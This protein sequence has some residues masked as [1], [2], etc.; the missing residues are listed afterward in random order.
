MISFSS[1]LKIPTLVA[2]PLLRY[3]SAPLERYAHDIFFYPIL[4]TEQMILH[5]S[6]VLCSK[7]VMSHFCSSVKL[8]RCESRWIMMTRALKSLHTFVGL[9]F[10]CLKKNKNKNNCDILLVS[11]KKC[12]PIENSFDA[13]QSCLTST[14]SRAIQ[15]IPYHNRW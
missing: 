3:E 2:I 9:F 11:A 10:W 1:F 15:E 8:C 7:N 14:T 4:K 5:F 12:N 13:T 6:M